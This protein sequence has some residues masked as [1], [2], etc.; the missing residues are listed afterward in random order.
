MK[1]IE[2]IIN[3]DRI[4]SM[5]DDIIRPEYLQ[6]SYKLK[7]E[8]PSFI[9]KSDVFFNSEYEAVGFIFSRLLDKIEDDKDNLVFDEPEHLNIDDWFIQK[10]NLEFGKS[11]NTMNDIPLVWKSSLLNTIKRKDLTFEIKIYYNKHFRVVSEFSISVF[12]KKNRK[13]VGETSAIFWGNLFDELLFDIYDKAKYLV[14]ISN[15]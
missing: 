6:Y 15:V 13:K 9:L 3:Q 12:T 10:M 5:I 1:A 4:F 8:M 14:Q 2:Y 11:S 7:K